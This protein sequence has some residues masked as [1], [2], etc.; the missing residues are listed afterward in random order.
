ME[1]GGGAYTRGGLYP[2]A[3]ITGI[4]KRFETSYGRADQKTFCAS[5]R[6]NKSITGGGG[7]GGV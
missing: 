2:R 4:E 7:G 1:L 6:H 5:K 3:R